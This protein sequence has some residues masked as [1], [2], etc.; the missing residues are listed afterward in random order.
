MR[1]DRG[2]GLDEDDVGVRGMALPRSLPRVLMVLFVAVVWWWGCGLLGQ[3]ARAACLRAYAA[4][5]SRRDSAAV[6]TMRLYGDGRRRR[7]RLKPCAVVREAML[8]G[9]GATAASPP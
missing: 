2:A 5:G 7:H 4:A 9:G 8:P 1:D 3:Q 6:D